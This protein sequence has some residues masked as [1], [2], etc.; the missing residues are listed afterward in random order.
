VRNGRLLGQIR[1]DRQPDGGSAEIDIAVGTM[2]RGQGLG[3]RL[4]TE[5]AAPV[6]RELAVS[7]LHA[8]VFVGNLSSMELFRRCGF[9]EVGTGIRDG[10]EIVQFIWRPTSS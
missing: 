7:A 5:T 9:S 6:C 1:H 8:T 4:L 10:R 3:R 2:G